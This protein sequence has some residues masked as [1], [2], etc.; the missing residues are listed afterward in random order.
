ML[1][2]SRLFGRTLTSTFRRYISVGETIPQTNL[3]IIEEV[4]GKFEKTTI[5]STALFKNQKVVIVGYPGCFTPTCEGIHLPQYIQRSADL[6]KTG[7]NKIYA[8][9]I[10]DPFVTASFAQKLN[11]GDKIAFI[12][13]GTGEFTKKLKM[14]TDLSSAGLGIRSKRYS[15][16]VNDNK[17]E[18]LND[19]GGPGFTNLSAVSQILEQARKNK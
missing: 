5:T 19:E 17:V 7:V 15:M 12:A 8:L 16:I 11:A 10:N 4:N 6:R 14:E 9:A 2:A 18:T 1:S 13:D 3:T